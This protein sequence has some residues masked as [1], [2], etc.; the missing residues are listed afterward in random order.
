M[1]GTVEEVRIAKRHMRGTRIHLLP[2]IGQH[3]VARNDEESSPIDRWNRT[4]ATAVLAATA[5]FDVSDHMRAAPAVETRILLQARQR[6][7]RRH[8]E[9]ELVEPYARHRAG[10]KSP[11]QRDEGV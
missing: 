8:R 7:A 1:T 5:R 3:N 11:R 10:V 2:D 6:G 9:I 4:V